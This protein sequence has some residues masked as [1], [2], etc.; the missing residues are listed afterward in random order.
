[1]ADRQ[2]PMGPKNLKCP[3]YRK[4]MSEVCHECPMWT[5]IKGKDPQSGEDLDRWECA[6]A[7]A[8]LLQ[9]EVARN[10]RQVQAATESF[11]NEM[12]KAQTALIQQGEAMKQQQLPNGNGKSE[13]YLV[14]PDQM[15]LIDEG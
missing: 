1:M 2:V 6:Y 13:D 7:L 11:R 8:P 14:H 9:I 12:I 4:P 3:L 10:V 15:K 5:C